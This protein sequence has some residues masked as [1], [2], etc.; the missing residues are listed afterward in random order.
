MARLHLPP[1]MRL[2]PPLDPRAPAPP[3]T[4]RHA[5]LINPF[6]PKDPHGSFGKHVLTPSLALT[7]LAAATPPSWSVA[8]WDENLLQGPPPLDPFPALVGITV[9]LTF[10]R[11]AYALAAWYRA[12]GALVVLGGLHVQS[13]PGEAPRA[14]RRAGLLG[15]ACAPG[16]GSWPTPSAAP[17]RPSTRGA[18]ARRSTRSR[19][20]GATAAA[21]QLP[22]HRQPHRHPRLPQPL[23]LLLPRDRGPRPPLPGQG[24]GR[25]GGRVA[26]HR[27]AVRGLPRQ[28]PRL[29]ARGT[30]ARSAARSRRSTGSGARPS[31]S[32]SPTTR[33]WCARWRWPAAPASSSASRRSTTRTCAPPASA[34]RPPRTTRAGCGS[35]TT[36]GSR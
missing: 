4:A 21:R 12:R 5:L 10:A 27:R 29:A 2:A 17:S 20:R 36:T 25:G 16:R 32:T 30:C 7:S 31:R 15:G 11:R 14:R 1:A 6:Y 26:G 23:R 22:D 18:T 3:P 24:P 28:Q 35:S 19:P 9:H 8:T 13:C 34:R 33:R